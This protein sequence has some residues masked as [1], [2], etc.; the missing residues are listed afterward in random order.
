MEK[1]DTKLIFNCGVCRK[2]L[3]YGCQIV[4]VKPDHENRDKTVFVFKKDAV[5]D[6]AME[7]ITKTINE[8]KNREAE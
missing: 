3:K 5:F 4:D 8:N 2:L 6:E 7:R 1:K